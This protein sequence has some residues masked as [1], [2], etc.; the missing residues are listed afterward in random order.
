MLQYD[1]IQQHAL[2]IRVYGLVQ[3]VGFRP[4]IHNL[5]TNLGLAG[6]AL[7][8]N[9]CVQI[10]VQGHLDC[11]W[12]D[13]FEGLSITLEADGFTMLTGPVADQA[14]L[15]GLLKRIHDLGLPLVSVNQVEESKTCS[16]K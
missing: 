7:N 14:A 12:S 1:E 5:A 16:T 9:D 13:W 11:D 3:G 8:R 4:F 2:D 10:R 15:Y 6:W